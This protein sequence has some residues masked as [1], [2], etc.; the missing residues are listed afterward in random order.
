MLEKSVT[1]AL[2]IGTSPFAKSPTEGDF[3]V[4]A[5]VLGMGVLAGLFALL[6]DGPVANAITLMTTETESFTLTAPQVLFTVTNNGNP[7]ATVDQQ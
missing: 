2:Q 5:K 4:R 3:N 1:L 6:A 7:P